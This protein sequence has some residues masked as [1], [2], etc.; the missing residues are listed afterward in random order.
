MGNVPF[1]SAFF[2]GLK[3]AV[4]AI[5]AEAVIR[6]GKKSLRNAT[7]VTLAALSFIGIYFLNIPFPAIV[8]SAGVI[9]YLGSRFS[10]DTF[11]KAKAA[12]GHGNSDVALSDK[13]LEEGRINPS[14]QRSL[15]VIAVSLLFWFTPVILLG[16][17]RGWNDIFIDI[18]I[19]YSKATVVTFGGAY[20]VLAYVSQQAVNH[21]HW[22]TPEQMIDG[23]GLA[24]TT[25]GPLIM[26]NQFVGYVAAFTHPTDLAPGI[27]GAIGGLLTTWVTFT[28]CFL[29]IFLG[30]PYIE[31]L[32][33]NIKLGSA[34]SAITAAIVGVVLNLSVIFIYHV[35]L[36]EGKGFDWYALAASVIAFVGMLRFKWGMIPV[37]IGSAAA[38]FLWKMVI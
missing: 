33:N 18:G 8:L 19:L 11:F 21:Y 28:P 20:A 4:V 9:G 29:W 26:V 32:R 34:L 6:I 17:W 24:E 25:P 7:L 22:L 16:L 38:G 15:K 27:A 1:V 2:Y 14:W 3:P 10:P 12:N 13:V 31:R 5:V 35:L 37:I 36:P 30:A 23:L